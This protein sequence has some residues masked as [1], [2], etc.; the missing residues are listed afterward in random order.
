MDDPHCLISW[1][2]AFIIDRIFKVKACVFVP[3]TFAIYQVY[4]TMLVSNSASLTDLYLSDSF[5]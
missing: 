4:V 1:T 3:L 5:D 2:H